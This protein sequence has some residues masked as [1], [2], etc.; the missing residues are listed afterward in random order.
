MGKNNVW[1]TG[2]SYT[3][4][5]DSVRP[6]KTPLTE[7]IKIMSKREVFWEYFMATGNIG[8]YLIFRGIDKNETPALYRI[9]GLGKR[10][11]LG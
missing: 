10:S 9:S 5:P 7:R 8:A 6:E 4:R 11:K 1:V 3:A 2:T